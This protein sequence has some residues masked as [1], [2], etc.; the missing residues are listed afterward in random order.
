MKIKSEIFVLARQRNAF[1]DSPIWFVRF[2]G[3]ACFLCS[4]SYSWLRA[5]IVFD[6][7]LM[8][9]M[10]K[11]WSHVIWEL[12]IKVD[13]RFVFSLFIN[14]LSA[15]FPHLLF[16]HIVTSST[17]YGSNIHD[18]FHRTI[19]APT[20]FFANICN[21]KKNSKDNAVG[22][23]SIQRWTLFSAFIG[24]LSIDLSWMAVTNSIPKWK[25]KFSEVIRRGFVY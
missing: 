25:S 23:P 18:H 19:F 22:M 5:S 24:K 11:K 6:F 20:L 12:K 2:K 21:K 13:L 7:V 1:V 10:N 16:G 17:S 15:V 3:I 14:F 9:R 4:L 8:S